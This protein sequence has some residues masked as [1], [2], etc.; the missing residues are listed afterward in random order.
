MFFTFIMKKKRKMM[1]KLSRIYE[2]FL[3]NI[4]MKKNVIRKSAIKS[5]FIF[6]S[7]IQLKLNKIAKKSFGIWSKKRNLIKT[8]T[9]PTYEKTKKS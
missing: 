2:N 9:L 7:W 6:I 4:K 8:K 1:I 3:M 5:I